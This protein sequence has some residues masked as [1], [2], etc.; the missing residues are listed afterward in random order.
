MEASRVIEVHEG[1]GEWEKHKKFN[2]LMLNTIPSAVFSVDNDGRITSW[3]KRAEQ[4]TGYSSEEILGKH[5]S[6]FALEPC[7]NQC[8]LF[9]SDV[10]KPVFEKICTIRSKQGD[11]L[12]ISKNADVFRDVS[13]AVI[14]GI[15]CFEDM[16]ERMK[17]E[18]E[19]QI[20]NERFKNLSEIFPETIY[21]SNLA[22]EIVYANK[23]GLRQFGYTETDVQRRLR[24]IDLVEP[25]HRQPVLQRTLDKLHGIDHGYLEYKA[26]RKDGSTFDA[27]GLS[28]AIMKNGAPIGFRG[29]VLDVTEQKKT[30]DALAHSEAKHKAMVAGIS[31]VI[32]IMD[33]NGIMKYKSP[34]IEKW[35]GWLPQDL[36]GTNGWETV[37]PDDVE[38]L[39]KEFAKILVEDNAMANV[40]YRYKCKDGTY[41]MIALTATN[42]VRNE[43]INGVLLNYHDITERKKLSGDL[44]KS[45]KR[46]NEAQQMAHI[47]NW[48]LDLASGQMW[49]SEEA[50]SIYGIDHD[51]PYLPLDVV[52][53]CV[54]AEYR[55]GMNRALADLIAGRADYDMD[56]KIRNHRTG[57]ERHVHSAAILLTDE[58]NRMQKV[59]G[60]V[61]D[62]T[63]QKMAEAELIQAKELADAANIAKSRFL[64]NMSHEIRTPM[65]GIFGFLELLQTSSLSSDQ[66]E[67]IREAKTA[68]TVL[69][70][71]INDILDFSKIEAGKLTM[72]NITFNLRTAVEDAVSLLAPKA[73]E[74][75]LDLHVM[76][77][78]GVPEEVIG[79]PSRVRQVLNNLV[80]NAVKFTE[81]GEVVVSVDSIEKEDEMAELSFAVRDTGIGISQEAM[82]NLFQSFSQADASTTRK[83]G[84]TGL[85]LAISKE[86]VKMMGGDMSADS[87]PGEGSVFRF[88]VFCRIAKRAS[89]QKE[90]F[91]H[92]E[93][94]NVLIVDDNV[95][96]RKIIGSYLQGAGLAVFEAK[97]V[98]N[99]ITTIIANANTKNKIGIA[100]ID[101]QMPGMS[102]FDLAA[103]LKSIPIAHD[104]KLI[105]LTSA[106]QK[107]DSRAA[108]EHGFS[109]YLTKPVR[110]DDLLSCLSIVL[111]LKKEEEAD[112]QVVTRYTVKEV[113]NAMKPK[114][115][116]AE[117]NAMNRKIVARILES[118]GMSCD[119]AA[120][121][122]EAYLALRKCEYDVVFMDCQ[123]PVM[124]GYESTSRIREDE[125]DG[126]HTTIIAMTANAM[127]GDRERCMAAGMDDYISKPIDFDRMFTLI[128]EYH[129]RKKTV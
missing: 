43:H 74:K 8:G 32:G 114:I 106:A 12:T 128:E 98:G 129:I 13:G 83:Y 14:G 18:E 122:R 62:V 61:Q 73:A 105:L 66:K 21:E 95:N 9:S 107:G 5:C 118:H 30:A 65:N 72:E 44:E 58:R 80:S 36:I 52:Q 124:D 10:I 27:L 90:V 96:N 102:G 54:C 117:D 29:F 121:G 53:G 126:K 59:C 85:G 38:W 46:L 57:E 88:H 123:M 7:R 26:L 25:A 23:H 24:V 50:F 82:T 4:I 19:L 127:E 125:G 41:K 1:A 15:E 108:K 37:H 47:G 70:N 6:C 11:I 48:E 94:T 60:T 17:M 56:F 49:A 2:D 101:Y 113:R 22:G 100:V 71:L 33:Q 75:N 76:I 103:A 93:G 40:E 77:Q 89:E 84:G 69:L 99:A 3:N 67:Y 104:I 31:D 35:F 55:E 45:E 110:R 116:L 87:I 64:A 34:N 79:D 68:S 119:M 42:L 28:V 39:Q 20:S 16:T 81:S 120:D 91:C 63:K 51:S 86:L 111:G 112:A 92:L 109:G 78:A 115:L 97:D